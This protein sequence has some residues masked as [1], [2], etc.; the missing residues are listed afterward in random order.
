MRRPPRAGGVDPEGRG[1]TGGADGG[2]WGKG[3]P[4]MERAGRCA[5][6]GKMGRAESWGAR[7]YPGPSLYV[8]GEGVWGRSDLSREGGG[9]CT[10][11]KPRVPGV[12]ALAAQSRAVGPGYCP[13]QGRKVAPG[14]LV[15]SCL[16][17]LLA[18]S[19]ETLGW[20]GAEARLRGGALFLSGALPPS[21]GW[22]FLSQM[23][24]QRGLGQGDGAR[25][26]G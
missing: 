23:W 11:G 12:F 4:G 13:W 9:L 25:R 22:L 2:G 3:F 17:D 14:V 1:A 26:R 5:Q 10:P 15:F 8:P 21:Q 16:A 24:L 20:E 18:S 6:P 19:G 7:S